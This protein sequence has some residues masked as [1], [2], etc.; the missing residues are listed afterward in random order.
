VGCPLHR[1]ISPAYASL[2]HQL[3]VRIFRPLDEHG[4]D[5]GLYAPCSEPRRLSGDSARGMDSSA[6]PANGRAAK[7]RHFSVFSIKK[8][9]SSAI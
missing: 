4:D 8:W 1:L 6:K 7:D 3:N 2:F 9:A 5:N